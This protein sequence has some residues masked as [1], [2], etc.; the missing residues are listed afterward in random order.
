MP[1][2]KHIIFNKKFIEYSVLTFDEF[3]IVN[4]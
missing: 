1:L 3:E 4:D 2:K